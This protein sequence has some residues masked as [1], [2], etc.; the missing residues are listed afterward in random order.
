M[1]KR[2]RATFITHAPN[3]FGERHE[4][5]IQVLEVRQEHK[6][7]WW[8]WTTWKEIDREIVPSAIWQQ[9]ATLGWTDWKSKWNGMPNVEWVKIKK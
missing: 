4:E 2:V 3:R 9:A 7:L 1:K 6:F 8:S 5:M